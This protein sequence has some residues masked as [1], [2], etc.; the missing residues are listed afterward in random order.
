MI[1]ANLE[2]EC[3]YLG[4]EMRLASPVDESILGQRPYAERAGIFVD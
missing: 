4:T 3:H 2:L 1:P